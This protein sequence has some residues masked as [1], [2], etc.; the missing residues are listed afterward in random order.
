MRPGEGFEL[1]LPAF[2]QIEAVGEGNVGW[3]SIAR[4]PAFMSLDAF[5]QLISE[6]P[7][8]KE[9]HFD[10]RRDPL[11][12][13]LLFDMVSYAAARGLA[14]SATSSAAMLG[15]RRAEE[16]VKSGLKRLDVALDAAPPARCVVRSLKRLA[17]TKARLGA[18]EPLVRIVASL[19]RSNVERLPAL[20][21]LARGIGAAALVIRELSYPSP[22]R[23]TRRQREVESL[24][25]ADEPRIAERLEA[26]RRRAA[27]LGIALEFDSQP[28]CERPWRAAY[29]AYSG[30]AAACERM[31]N[32]GSHLGNMRGEGVRR[33]WL[34]EAYRA[35]R[36]QLAS[37][38]PPAMCRGCALYPGERDA[39]AANLSARA[40][41]T[42]ASTAFQSAI[43]R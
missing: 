40:P 28:R 4:S 26:A 13:P 37:A 16:C 5:R 30:E 9:I 6:F 35:F 25:A 34:G 15:E 29:I 7:A 39:Y 3:P 20:L 14:V 1:P 27:E 2:V 11:L 21:T 38:E 23:M 36:E 43:K 32:G 42:S 18:R 31:A 8:L 33:V 10:G 41:V 17:Q 12:H 24:D 22:R 19:T